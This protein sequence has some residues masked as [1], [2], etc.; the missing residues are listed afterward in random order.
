VGNA[1]M[2][3]LEQQDVRSSTPDGASCTTLHFTLYKRRIKRKENTNT[4][5]VSMYKTASG[6]L[7]EECKKWCAQGLNI[8]P[9]CKGSVERRT[10]SVV[11]NV[12]ITRAVDTDCVHASCRT[13]CPWHRP[14]ELIG[15]R[16]G[17]AYIAHGGMII[18]ACS[19]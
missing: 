3:C 16:G 7:Y 5:M 8:T 18:R 10:G 9:A 6:A 11:T 14:R 19:I 12:P 2:F 15:I 13:R 17:S 1:L 4:H